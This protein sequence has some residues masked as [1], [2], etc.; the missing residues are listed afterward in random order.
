M[1][2]WLNCWGVHYLM[3]SG[4]VARL[5]PHK[6]AKCGEG[7]GTRPGDKMAVLKLQAHSRCSLINS[8]GLVTDTTSKAQ[9][10]STILCSFAG[11]LH[12]LSVITFRPYQCQPSWGRGCGL[13]RRGRVPPS[14][15]LLQGIASKQSMV[16]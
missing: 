10:I 16:K 3:P 7:L 13:Q 1:S 11:S 9:L 15:T 8:Y 5:F 14:M 4:L 2:I 12:S 6:R